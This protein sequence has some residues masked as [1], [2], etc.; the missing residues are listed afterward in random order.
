MIAGAS[1][2]ENEQITENGKK[3]VWVIDDNGYDSQLIPLKYDDVFKGTPL[4]GKY[5]TKKITDIKQADTI[6]ETKQEKHWKIYVDTNLWDGKGG[7]YSHSQLQRLVM[8][9][10]LEYDA[11]YDRKIKSSSP[12]KKK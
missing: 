11:R 2:V 12:E 1:M 5:V 7:N 8:L 10:I 4:S 9:A 6:D 3:Y